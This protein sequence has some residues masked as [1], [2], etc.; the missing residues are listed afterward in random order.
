MRQEGEIIGYGSPS[1]NPHSLEDPLIKSH[2]LEVAGNQ[3]MM[4]TGSQAS[5]S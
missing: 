5:D 3:V 1:L 2:W 4:I